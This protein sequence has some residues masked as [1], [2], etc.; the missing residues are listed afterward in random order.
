MLCG[1][2][3]AEFAFEGEFLD[4]FAGGGLFALGEVGR[5]FFGVARASN[6]GH[7]HD[8]VAFGHAE[9]LFGAVIIEPGHAVHHQAELVPLQG[10]VLPGGAGVVGVRGV[11]FVVVLE[12][13]AR[14]DDEEGGGVFAP[15]LVKLDQQVEEAG[16]GFG[17]AQG[18]EKSPGLTVEAGGRPAGRFEEAH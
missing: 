14:D 6:R 9:H 15:L 17:I 4:G 18:I 2:R 10:E 12:G 13:L 16:P 8:C 5:Q 11:G 7:G 3:L 1:S